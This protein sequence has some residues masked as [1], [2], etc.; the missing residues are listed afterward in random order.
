MDLL[1][2]VFKNTEAQS[3]REENELGLIEENA[4]LGA[5][6]WKI[7]KGME[8]GTRLQGY[9]DQPAYLRGDTLH[10]HASTSVPEG[11]T[12]SIR[13]LRMGWYGGMGA[14]QVA[15][16]EK[17]DVS[18]NNVWNES[19]GENNSF[20][21]SSCDWDSIFSIVIP[22]EW[23][24]GL[25]CIRFELQDNSAYLHP[26]YISDETLSGITLVFSSITNQARNWWG[27]A[28]ATHC[29]NRR[30]KR[31]KNLYFPIGAERLTFQ[32]PMYNS[33]AGDAL[34]WDYP[35]IRFLERNGIEVSYVADIALSVNYS[36]S[37]SP[38][39]IVTTGPSRYWSKNMNEWFEDVVKKGAKYI[40]FGS[41]A[42]QNI[43]EIC[44]QEKSKFIQLHTQKYNGQYGERVENS[45]T[46]AKISGS[47]PYQPWGD[48]WLDSGD[49]IP[50]VLGTSWDAS[51]EGGH[52]NL[53]IL[54]TGKARHS[55]LRF[56]KAE[57]FKK[58]HGKGTVVNV[59]CSNWTW[60]LSAFGKQGNIR[61]SQQCQ[62]VTWDLL[63]LPKNQLNLDDDNE[64][65]F[66][67]INPEPKHSL[68][69]LNSMIQLNPDNHDAILYAAIQLF[70]A[71]RYNDCLTYLE[72][73]ISI[74]PNTI[75][76]KYY[77]AR[78]LYKQKR[79]HE[80]IPMYRELLKLRPDRYHYVIQ[81]AQILIEIGDF[82]GAREVLEGA[83]RMRKNDARGMMMFGYLA[84]REKNFSLAEEYL[85][86]AL[87]L[88]PHHKQTLVNLGTV[89]QEKFDF[90]KSK[91]CWVEVLNND[92]SHYSALMGMARADMK[93]GDF[94]SAEAYLKSITDNPEHEHRYWPYVELM[95]L[96]YNQRKDYDE[97]IKYARQA[98]TKASSS[99]IEKEHLQHIPVVHECLAYLEKN[100]SSKALEIA[101]DFH[102]RWPKNV[103]IILLLSRIYRSLGDN[104]RGWEFFK[105]IFGELEIKNP[106]HSEKDDLSYSV[107]SLGF[108]KLVRRVS[109]EPLVSVIMTAY[110]AEDLIHNAVNSILHQ[111]WQNLE[112][113]I[114][115]DCSP[116]DT[117]SMLESL[118]DSDDRIRIFRTP[119]NG[120]T[121]VAKNYGL[122]KA[123]GEYITFHDSDDW[124]HPEKIRLQVE[125][126]RNSPVHVLGS[127]TNYIRVDENSTIHFRGKGAIRHACITLMIKKEILGTIGYFDS[128]RVSADSE[129]ERRI[130][131]VYGRESLFHHE[132]PLLIASV[133]SE[134]LS[135]GG[136][137][138]LEWN[139]ITGARMEYRAA[140]ERWH[141]EL[142]LG[143]T[144]RMMEIT[145]QRRP[146]PAPHEIIW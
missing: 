99:M 5:I 113:I 122:S 124:L 1:T 110:K 18:H 71:S 68:Q 11:T 119:K 85:T 72:R 28:S 134:S 100:E 34:R 133:R 130:M 66:V 86:K 32:R 21:S 20:I 91:K 142:R 40:H 87:E 37:S 90:N 14:R 39:K 106:I 96:L 95:N 59:G 135:Q 52:E 54:G 73:A 46:G 61:V 30:P 33:R 79:F 98:R 114:V 116:D 141:E 145:P 22:D 9:T 19:S 120:G 4:M 7:P 23:H 53:N 136:K 70:N 84:R 24:S 57:F 123:K 8:T 58:Q 143:E 29:T 43:V 44:H 75:Q 36:S 107:E 78:C 35:L 2:S 108:S 25:Y 94:Q 103:E 69:E 105:R 125:H 101:M 117:F 3:P 140:F 55:F 97:V 121:Y 126:L 67:E 31:I 17:L 10:I 138:A 83:L 144:K 137:F 48:L 111:S 146:F 88:D 118:R 65:V 63:E 77:K 82:S 13:I 127:T 129:F 62:R 56:R 51:I 16:F 15:A 60:A 131:A 50:G 115:D 12:C 93:T 74:R 45:F 102:E 81:Y 27:G 92:P 112:L 64:D 41:E 47:K 49:V 139:G 132:L 42:G 80:T 104:N 26:F 128:V 38:T 109:A 76:S 89:Y 6:G